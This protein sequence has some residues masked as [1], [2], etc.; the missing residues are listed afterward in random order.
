MI[1]YLE[2]IRTPW[3]SSTQSKSI[4]KYSNE[5]EVLNKTLEKRIEE[6]KRKNRKRIEQKQKKNRKRNEQKQKK[7]KRKKIKE[8]ILY[9]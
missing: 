8:N 9:N 5:V 2:L 7:N 1:K 6:K 4:E 3:L